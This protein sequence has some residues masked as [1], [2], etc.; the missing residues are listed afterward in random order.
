MDASTALASAADAPAPAAPSP[1]RTTPDAASNMID[2]EAALHAHP[3]FA[4]LEDDAPGFFGTLLS[5][6]SVR[7][8]AA[9]DWIVRVGE[10]GRALFLV[11]R[12]S[13]IVTGKDGETVYSTLGPGSF[14]GEIA[15]AM[16]LLRTANV[17]A[18]ERCVLVVIQKRDLQQTLLTKFGP[19]LST[20]IRHAAEVRLGRSNGNGVAPASSAGA[21]SSAPAAASAAA[22]TATH[23]LTSMVGTT[24]AGRPATAA[25][26]HE[27]IT[28][29]AAASATPDFNNSG[30]TAGA[31][32]D[33]PPVRHAL[34]MQHSLNSSTV[35]INGVGLS[36]SDRALLD[37]HRS[38]SATHVNVHDMLSAIKV[39]TTAS[40]VSLDSLLAG[41]DAASPTGSMTVPTAAPA[42]PVE[43]KTL[44]SISA[45]AP[46]K[47]RASVAVWS[48]PRLMKMAS[49]AMAKVSVP[50]RQ[51]AAGG[52]FSSSESF[53]SPSALSMTLSVSD[54]HA[55][56]NKLHDATAAHAVG[57]DE[58]KITMLDVL[59]CERASTRI[60]QKLSTRDCFIVRGV[61]TDWFDWIQETRAVW[62]THVAFEQLKTIDDGVLA[63]IARDCAPFIRVLNL[64]N[65]FA[66]TDLGFAPLLLRCTNLEELVLH[67]CWEV[68]GN[69]FLGA[70]TVCLPSVTSLDL[71][72]L[73]K[74]DDRAL[75]KCLLMFPNLTNLN[76]GYCKTLGTGMFVTE[77]A[78]MAM[79]PGAKSGPS[80]ATGLARWGPHSAPAT[81]TGAMLP[82]AAGGGTSGKGHH[83]HGES[84]ATGTAPPPLLVSTGITWRTIRSLNLQRCTGLRDDAFAQWPVIGPSWSLETLLL[85]DCSL[86]TDGALH[87]ISHTCPQL[88]TLGLAFCCALSEQAMAAIVRLDQ[89]RVLDLSF[90]GSLV[91]DASV[92][93]LVR[94]CLALEALG[95][96]GC[97]RVDD[98]ILDHVLDRC[99]APALTP[100]ARPVTST[101]GLNGSSG[102]LSSGGSR[103]ST[104]PP[105]GTSKSGRRRGSRAGSETD[106]MPASPSTRGPLPPLPLKMINV[107]Q[108][109]AVSPAMRAKLA[110]HVRC[111]ETESVVDATLGAAETGARRTSLAA[112]VPAL[113]APPVVVRPK[114]RVA[115]AAVAHLEH[116]K[117]GEANVVTATLGRSPA[118]ARMQ[119][120]GAGQ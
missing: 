115:P 56:A 100:H 58:H 75:R 60:L 10:E 105:A 112:N 4:G 15:V 118:G 91:S 108:C 17:V 70:G 74:I 57:D 29:Q 52:R 50:I 38:E 110:A 111:L 80:S 47:R 19:S 22:A 45:Q 72:N 69:S 71:S 85:G 51:G 96:R 84:G 55:S 40:P 113:A 32:A 20:R 76:L 99:T 94:K 11:L 78:A 114:P 68:S 54:V 102:S 6:V 82:A 18:L 31:R 23:Q 44:S 49:D 93:L 106:A 61:C 13:V 67:N 21:T 8:A 26:L 37:M 64:K 2:L 12:G 48:D 34:A 92:R 46:S 14:F 103:P 7:Y 73:R 77:S 101:S 16:D 90:C 86:L 116:R 35:T 65:C 27:I 98:A 24:S 39:G 89:L 97:V 62:A 87:M 83:H 53:R 119:G 30:S 42:V 107:S 81:A 66:V 3:L 88:R 95:M 109:R 36:G 104:P 41:E 120:A 117:L 28:L 33:F 9:G 1:V 5:L 59:R 25:G 79:V 43:H 63:L